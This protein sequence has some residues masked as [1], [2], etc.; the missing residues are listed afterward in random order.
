MVLDEVS[1]LE[2][3]SLLGPPPG[4]QACPVLRRGLRASTSLHSGAAAISINSSAL[5]R[6]ACG[7][8]ETKKPEEKALGSAESSRGRKKIPQEQRSGGFCASAGTSGRVCFVC[9]FPSVVSSSVT[10]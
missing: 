7:G 9:F 2:Q 6:H 10:P 4:A 8:P 1:S 5:D 3:K